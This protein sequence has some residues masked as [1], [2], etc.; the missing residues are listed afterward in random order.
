MR[1]KLTNFAL[2]VNIA[3]IGSQKS[4]SRG[5]KK[6]IISKRYVDFSPPG[7]L[8]ELDFR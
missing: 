6:G 4:E 5:L 7:N 1:T 3:G 2:G 8:T